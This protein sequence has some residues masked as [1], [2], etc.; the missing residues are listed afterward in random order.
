[1]SINPGVANPADFDH[2]AYKGGSDT[3]IINMTT[4]V[5]T[6][7]GTKLCFSATAN[8]STHDVNETAFE[9]AYG[10]ALRQLDGL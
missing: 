9:E 6:H 4:M 5:T 8:D 10:A 1:M 7:H 2:V 3:G